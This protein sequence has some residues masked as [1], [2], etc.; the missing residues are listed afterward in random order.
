MIPSAERS[1]KRTQPKQQLR[2]E[3]EQPLLE[4]ISD[5]VPVNCNSQRA[6]L[7]Y[8]IPAKLAAIA[9]YGRMDG[10]DWIAWPVIRVPACSLPC[11]ECFQR[12]VLQK[13]HTNA[14]DSGA[15]SRRVVMEGRARLVPTR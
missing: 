12:S 4:R 6:R 2:V 7:L 15:R 1:R 10:W 9:L 14:Y 13:R 5:V 11:T 8:A 3:Q